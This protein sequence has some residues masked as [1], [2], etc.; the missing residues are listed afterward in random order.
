MV[1]IRKL[2]LKKKEKKKSQPPGKLPMEA[3][4]LFAHLS[5]FLLR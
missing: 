4:H 3:L 1:V 5:V 2:C